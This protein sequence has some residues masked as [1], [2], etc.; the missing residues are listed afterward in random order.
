MVFPLN[1][2]F[3]VENGP[4]QIQTLFRYLYRRKFVRDFLIP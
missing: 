3:V 1:S 4:S 2:K